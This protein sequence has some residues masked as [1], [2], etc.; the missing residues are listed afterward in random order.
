MGFGSRTSWPRAGRVLRDVGTTNRTRI[1]DYERSINERTRLLLRSIPQIF[2]LQDSRVSLEDLIGLGR[3]NQIPVYEGNW[4]SV[5]AAVI[6][7][8][9]TRGTAQ[10]PLDFPPGG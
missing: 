7:T 5:D 2:G 9:L 1:R 8:D 10:V 3:R 4:T 6:R